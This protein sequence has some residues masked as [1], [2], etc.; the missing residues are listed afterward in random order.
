MNAAADVVFGLIVLL[1]AA[2]AITAVLFFLLALRG[3]FRWMTRSTWNDVVRS[4]ESHALAGARR[5]EQA[6]K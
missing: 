6:L 2:G 1:A 4:T 5:K 3:F